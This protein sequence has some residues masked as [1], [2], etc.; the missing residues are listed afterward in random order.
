VEFVSVELIFEGM[1]S[2]TYDKKI[3]LGWLVGSAGPFDNGY[4]GRSSGSGT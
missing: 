3:E 4:F 1:I 2:E